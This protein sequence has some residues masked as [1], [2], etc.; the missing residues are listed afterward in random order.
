MSDA[1]YVT[2][3]E[4]LVR[5]QKPRRSLWLHLCEIMESLHEEEEIQAA[6][7]RLEP[8]LESW[9]PAQR[10]TPEPW[11]ERLLEG[12]PLDWMAI[13]R[14]LD[15][16]GKQIGYVDADLLSQSP[17]LLFIE[18]LNLA[19]NG[20]QNSGTQ[21]L[22]SAPV[23]ANLTHLDLAGNS[24]E[25]AG[26]EA[27]TQ[28]EHLSKLTYLDLT[29]NWV[30]DQAAELIAQCPYFSNLETLILRGNPVKQ[31]GAEALAHSPHLKEEIK[32]KWATP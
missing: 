7:E 1:D 20:L 16:R 6:T 26:V 32:Q 10:F 4:E 23:I 11:I 9:T 18:H 17:E 3:M 13:T 5:D 14:T 8:L 27:L 30:D 12:E 31:A 25:F 28:C 21:A 29:G 22:L 15:L 19:Y 2:Q 24:V